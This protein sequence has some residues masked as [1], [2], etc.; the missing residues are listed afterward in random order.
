M[1]ATD[2]PPDPST[3][4]LRLLCGLLL[5][6]ST[7]LFGIYLWFVL[8]HEPILGDFFVLWAAAGQALH[9]P[10]ATV[11]DP[12][13]FTAYKWAYTQGR[14]AQYPFLYPP[15]TALLL[16]PLARLPYGAALLCWDLVSLAVYLAGAWLLLWPRWTTL[17]A[18]VAPATVVCLL[19]GQGGLLCSG[20]AL[21]GFALLPRRPLWAGALLGLLVLKPQFALLPLLVLA[22]SGQWRAGIA[23]LAVVAALVAGSSAVFGID[24]W[25][26]WLRHLGDFSGNVSSSQAHREYGITVYFALLALGLD[27]RV[28]LALQAL[29]SLAVLWLVGRALRRSV[30]AATT[31]LPLLGIYLA[32]PYAAAYDLPAMSA[33]CL[34]LLASGWRNGFHNGELLLL[35][36]AWSLPFVVMFSPVPLYAVAAATLALLFALALRQAAKGSP[37]IG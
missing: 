30:R 10:L 31:A 36:V 34:I 12:A 32:T 8:R 6:C 9:E 16:L 14:L 35:T 18:L 22:G 19:S 5:A 33:A 25:S 20:L 29:V 2:A 17:A 7:L 26:A 37:A 23:A 1:R 11:Y 28:A 4:P 13:A 21:L 3:V 15:H 24:A 27:H